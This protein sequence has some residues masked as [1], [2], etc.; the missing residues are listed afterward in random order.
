MM[1]VKISDILSSINGLKSLVDKPMSAKTA[2]RVKRIMDAVTS[3]SMHVEKVRNSLIMK[4]ADK[5]TKEQ[6]EKKESPKVTK[7]IKEFYEEFGEVLNEEIEVNCNLLPFSDIENI[8]LTV[9]DLVVLSTWF[10]IPEEAPLI[11]ARKE[12]E[13]EDNLPSGVTKK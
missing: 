3:E 2:Y 7:K 8:E 11:A 4:Y 13:K 6:I 12:E 10:D 5:Q 1:K 9:Q